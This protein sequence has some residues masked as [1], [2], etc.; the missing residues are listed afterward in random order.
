[1]WSEHCGNDSSFFGVEEA[2]TG[3]TD[4]ME[5]AAAPLQ[6]PVCRIDPLPIGHQPSVQLTQLR[7]ISMPVKHSPVATARI[8]A[9][10][11]VLAEIKRRVLHTLKPKH[12]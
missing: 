5:P 4:F 10:E 2:V 11:P 8:E 7:R 6:R 9:S 3:K 12:A 1:M